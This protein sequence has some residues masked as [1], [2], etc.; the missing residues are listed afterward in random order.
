MVGII[1]HAWLDKDDKSPAIYV[2]HIKHIQNLCHVA[3]TMELQYMTFLILL[4]LSYTILYLYNYFKAC[5][6]IEALQQWNPQC[7]MK[8]SVLPAQ[9]QKVHI[10]LLY[11]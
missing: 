1:M 3:I 7:A 8:C 4:I 9:S 6:N 5:P 2:L 11:K 10:L